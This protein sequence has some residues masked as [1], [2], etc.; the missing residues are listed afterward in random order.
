MRSLER[1]KGFLYIDSP[2]QG[3]HRLLGPSSGQD[4][5]GGAQNRVTDGP[6]KSQGG[7]ASH[8]AIDAPFKG[9]SQRQVLS[10]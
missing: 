4:A 5:S 2:Q 9:R 8:D 7:L 6:C 3:D 10:S 1:Y